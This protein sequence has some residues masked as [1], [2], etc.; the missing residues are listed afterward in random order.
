MRAA[1]V[2]SAAQ[3]RS[4]AQVLGLAAQRLEHIPSHQLLVPGS[5][6]LLGALELARPAQKLVTARA[7]AFETLGIQA[8]KPIRLC[9]TTMSCRPPSSGA[10][11]GVA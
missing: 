4:S 7:K 5:G 2:Q 1:T 6:S 9:R 11:A 8:I 3:E 10:A